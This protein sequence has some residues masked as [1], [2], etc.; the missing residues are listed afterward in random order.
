V[1]FGRERECELIDRLLDRARAGRA[2]AL[3]LRGEAGV[4]KSALLDYAGERADGMVVRAL[5]VE[6]EV[7]L[8]FSALLEVCRPLL[9]RLGGLPAGQGAALRGV[10]GLGPAEAVDRFLVGVSTLSLL[11]AV[12]EEDGPLLV[13]VDDAQWL[14]RSSAG[15]VVF[16][17]RRLEAD[18]VAF[19]FAAR[20][21]EEDGFRAPGIETVVLEGLEP[22]AAGALLG[23]AS[24]VPVAPRVGAAVHAATRGNP[25]ALVELPALL[26][27][28]QLAGLEPLADPL[29]VGAGLERAFGGRVGALPESA[30]EALLVAAVHGSQEMGPVVAALE[31]FGI[32]AG[33]LERA[34]DAGLVRI[35]DGG[36]AFRHPLVRSAVFHGA[37]PSKRRA[38][39]QALGRAL[40]GRGREDERAWHLAAAAL[41]PDEEAADALA[42]AG[43]RAREHSGYAVAAAALDR[44][45]RLSPGEDARRRRLYEAA[46]AAWTAGMSDR[47]RALLEEAMA[48]AED[49]LLLAAMLHLRGQIEHLAGNVPDAIELLG[50]AA[51][52]A[53]RDDADAAVAMLSDAVEACMFGDAPSAALRHGTR[54]RALAPEDGGV[55][56]FLAERALGAGLFLCGRAVEAERRLDRALGILDA[57]PAL[58]RDA[59]TLALAA[60][61]ASW[62]DRLEQG[63]EI[64]D[65][66]IETA[67]RDGAFAVLAH[68]LE[69]AAWLTMRQG[70]WR[71]AYAFASQGLTLGRETG[72]TTVTA[73][74]LSHL[75]LMD[76]AAG[77]ESRCRAH[78]AEALEL[79]RAR[80]IVSQWPERALALLDLG[81]GRL[82]EAAGRLEAVESSIVERGYY[83]RGANLV[84][85]YYRL[86]RLEQARA[87]FERYFALDAQTSFADACALAARCRGLLAGDD[88]FE[89]HFREAIDLH[90]GIGDAF[91]LARTR[92]CLGERLRRA[93]RKLHARTELRAALAACEEL[94][95]DPWATRTRA[96]LR[97]SG[98]TLRRRE[99]EQG[100]QL[101]PQELQVALQAAAGKTNK[102]AALALFLSPKTID[103]HLRRVY[104]KLN[105]RSRAEL[106]RHFATAPGS[107]TDHR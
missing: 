5:G 68:G 46:D 58:A 38:A 107:S 84:E 8:E 39:H 15:A 90:A 64:A 16:A 2:G 40:A 62:L 83:D 99:P 31:R 41:G 52:L 43:R 29:P 30:R 82:D 45:A 106:A 81:L 102:Q 19:L 80:G 7:E 35:G 103:F 36:I 71:E 42:A 27:P 92:L 53:A 66:A 50:N 74:C 9:G 57:S 93:G 63:L 89:P 98:A 6:S 70:R 101:T 48:G 33:W 60:I 85:A 88:R 105:V 11:A 51:S 94:G 76:A 78:A 77:R 100:E 34:E 67:R 14:D 65:R 75:A 44:A 37:S 13:L 87:A 1:L 49:P 26:T 72:G 54:A 25:L 20:T 59:R 18:R 91:G 73:Y 12:A 69:I 28:A 10:L 95:A 24:P 104:R 86:G 17:A 56:D 21:G 4:G 55:A 23:S 32:D 3:V 96:E 97:A 79:A 22:E 47:A 61:A